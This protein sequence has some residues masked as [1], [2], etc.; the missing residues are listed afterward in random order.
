M[1]D[2]RKKEKKE[3][4]GKRKVEEKKEKGVIER[5]R[6]K[7]DIILHFYVPNSRVETFFTFLDFE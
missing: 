1:K 6:R 4:E 3:R 2:L 5:E 7:K